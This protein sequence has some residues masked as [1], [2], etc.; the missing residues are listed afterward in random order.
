MD[1]FVIIA[2]PGLAS[3]VQ[4]SGDKHRERVAQANPRKPSCFPT[5]SQPCGWMNDHDKQPLGSYFASSNNISQKIAPCGFMDSQLRCPLI[6][7]YS[8]E[9]GEW[10]MQHNAAADLSIASFLRW[11]TDRRLT[12]SSSLDQAS[13]RRSGSGSRSHFRGIIHSSQSYASWP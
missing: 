9:R 1:L 11:F 4:F 2:L 6:S 12:E 7:L 10:T 3:I 5:L 8:G 13:L